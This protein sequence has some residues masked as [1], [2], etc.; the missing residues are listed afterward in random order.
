MN[1]RTLILVGLLAMSGQSNAAYFTA[2]DLLQECESTNVIRQITCEGYL[3]GIVDV[4]ETYQGWEI[5]KQKPFCMPAGV[6]SLQLEKV[7]IKHAN[8]NPQSLHLGAGSL[9]A[10]AFRVAFPCE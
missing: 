7:F 6:N 1:I 4:T 2:S 8:E 10:K 9:V 3:M 5:L